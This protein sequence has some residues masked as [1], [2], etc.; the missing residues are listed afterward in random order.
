MDASAIRRK[1]AEWAK[2]DR[3]KEE[4]ERQATKEEGERFR[5][6][7]SPGTNASRRA[8]T[9][10]EQ[11]REC[12]KKYS[13]DTEARWGCKGKK[14]KKQEP[15]YWFGYKRHYCVDTSSGMIE[16][17]AVTPAN[18]NDA[19]AFPL[20]CPWGKRILADRG[21]DT[22]LVRDTMKDKRLYRPSDAFDKKEK[23][24]IYNATKI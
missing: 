19:T 5:K 4:E 13:A 14:G 1:E 17:L 18:V 15:K 20:V 9:S 11:R 24:S 2:R 16:K 6:R 21:Y 8:D 3:E 10:S 7:A 22:W 12:I 23:T